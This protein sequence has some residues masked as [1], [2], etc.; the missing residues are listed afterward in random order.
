F[1]DWIRDSLRENKPYDQF[2]RGV[3][4]A[5]GDSDANPPVVWYREVKETSAQLEDS[6]Q[7]FLGQR[8]GCAR[9]HHHPFEKW[10]QQDYYGLAACFSKLD[11]K[12]PPAAKP[13]KGE[14]AP[15]KPPVQVSLKGGAAQATNPRTNK[16]VPAA[17]LGGKPLTV[18][19]D[20]DPR[21]K[22]V[23]WMVEKDNPFFAKAL[24]NR[25]WKHFLGRGLVEPE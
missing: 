22:L 3:L 6:A 13:K 24:V 20:E 17:G 12:D 15:P 23:D 4:T 11:V 21:A 5:T 25:Y 9:C 8:I 18:A 2:V 7:L 16:L 14:Q 10:S 19:A 1:H